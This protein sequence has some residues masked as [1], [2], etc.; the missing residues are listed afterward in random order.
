MAQRIYTVCDAHAAN[1]EDSPG[2]AWEVTLKGPGITKGATWEIDLCE[3]DG[4][5]LTDLA[6]MLDAV[7]RRTAGRAVAASAARVSSSGSARSAPR[8]RSDATPLPY[9]DDG[10][11]T[12]PVCGK[13]PVS[14]K[15]MQSHLRQYHDGMTVA[16]AFNLPEP[17]ACPECEF[18]SAAPQGLAAHR[19]QVHG[20]V[21]GAG[22]SSGG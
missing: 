3:Q 11:V 1:D 6:V 18:R 8:D 17:H 10:S 13:R 9:N 19:K 12:C 2:Q 15:A 21:V 4:K 14:R 20:H 5:T 22:E 16:R 7:G